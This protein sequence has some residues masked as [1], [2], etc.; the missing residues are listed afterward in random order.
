MYAK[1]MSKQDD[2]KKCLYCEAP[3]EGHGRRKFCSEDCYIQNK[4]QKQSEIWF[5]YKDQRSDFKETSCEYCGDPI[6]VLASKRGVVSHPEC[7][8]IMRQER[9]RRKNDKRRRFP[10]RKQKANF[11]TVAERDNWTCWICELRIDPEVPSTNRMGG[12]VDHVV[13]ISKGGTDD[14]DNLKPAHWICNV[15]RG[16]RVD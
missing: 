14:W 1:K 5:R 15:K 3:F 7:Q 9:N 12:T 11:H 4:I 2:R 8:I 16:N 10:Y 13:P 6:I